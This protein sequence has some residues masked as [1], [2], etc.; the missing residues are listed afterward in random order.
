MSVPIE[1]HR[2]DAY[3]LLTP[4][5]LGNALVSSQVVHKA[6]IDVG[7]KGTEAAAATGMSVG[8]TSVRVDPRTT[9]KFNRPFL[10]SIISK[11]TQS[12]LFC[13]KVAHPNEI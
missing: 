1:A 3:L 5:A 12:I 2:Q 7:E 6:L 8:I 11:D 10:L 13:G 9:V 4:P